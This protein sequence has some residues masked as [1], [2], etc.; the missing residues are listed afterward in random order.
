MNAARS[1]VKSLIKLNQV[2]YC[3]S[4]SCRNFSRC[5][6]RAFDLCARRLLECGLTAC[7]FFKVT[8]SF[9]RCFW[10]WIRFHRIYK[11]CIYTVPFHLS[12]TSMPTYVQWWTG[13]TDLWTVAKVL[14]WV[15]N[16]TLSQS[17]SGHFVDRHVKYS[18]SPWAVGTCVH[19]VDDVT[20]CQLFKINTIADVLLLHVTLSPSFAAAQ[21]A[22][23][24][25]TSMLARF[26]VGKRS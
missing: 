5:R 4:C 15:A 16:E 9:F 20:P 11:R 18:V 3:D 13:L 23:L 24:S 19:H 21:V 2:T 6:L 7:V 12:W 26:T 8:V 17:M 25:K 1:W 22:C 14:S 10:D